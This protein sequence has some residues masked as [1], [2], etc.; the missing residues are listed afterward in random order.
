MS[1]RKKIVIVNRRYFPSSGPETYLFNIIPVL[2]ADNFE[3]IPFSVKRKWNIKTKYE[4]YFVDSPYGL[5]TLY[6]SEAKLNLFSK[7][8]IFCNAIYSFEAK[9]KMEQLIKNEKPDLVYLFG[10]VNDISPSII[11]ACKKY[12]VPVMVRL[13]D[14][15]LL[16]ANYLFL[17]KNEFCKLCLTKN[18]LHGLKN[19]CVKNEFLPTLTRTLS[20]I[21]H[22]MMKIYDYVDSYICTCSFMKRIMIEGGF[23]EH[24]LHIINSFVDSESYKPNYKNGDYILYF[25][26]IS[27]EKGIEYLLKAKAKMKH[28]IPL[29]IVGETSDTEYMNSLKNYVINNNVPDVKFTGFK[30]TE[31]LKK[32]IGEAKFVVIP[33]ICADNSPVSALEAMASGKPIIGSDIGGIT[34]QITKDTGFLVSPKD[35]N[36]LAEKMDI[37]SE[38]D[39]MVDKMGR[40]A[41]INFE[42]NFSEKQHYS[43]L[44]RVIK[45]S[46][47]DAN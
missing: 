6:Y 17:R 13:S 35:E 34:D 37:L 29:Y 32:I 5:D 12:H 18:H 1:K 8:K 24:K 23:P 44:K 30:K 39:K 26:R 33:S 41:R 22:N 25:G 2:E 7:F 47:E 20:L 21:I 9:S 14:Y 3:V 16:C 42:E 36:Q 43:K 15:Y 11:H 4:K 40:N 31:E 46:L 28:K 27:P 45:K 10:I 19:L 38:N